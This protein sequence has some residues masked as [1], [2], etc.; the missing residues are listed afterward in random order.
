MGDGMARQARRTWATVAIGLGAAG[1][2]AFAACNGD[3]TPPAF[4]PEGGTS[5]VTTSDAS[6]DVASDAPDAA[7]ENA[8]VIT[9]HG[10]PDLP[11]FRVCFAIGT[12]GD[13][14]D[15][16]MAPLPPLPDR[17]SGSQPYPGIFPGTGGPM[18]DLLT[19]L[20]TK[21]IT[22]YLV[23]A[24]S[25]KTIE[26]VDGGTITGCDKLIGGDAGTLA[27]GTDYV[28]LGTI[29]PGTLA[30]NSTLVLVGTGCLPI[31]DDPSATSLRCGADYNG[32]T[33]NLAVKVFVLDRNVTDSAKVGVRVIHASQPL[34]G[35][36]NAG[37][38][39]GLVAS[40]TSVFDGGSGTATLVG[41]GEA[42][43]FGEQK[44]AKST[45]TTFPAAA[46]GT[47]TVAEA[48]ADGGTLVSAPFPLTTIHQLST[49]TTT[50]ADA[51]FANGQNVVF[52][53]VGDPSVALVTDAGINGYG[54][55]VLGFPTNPAVV[56]YP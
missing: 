52:V 12:K 3:D 54:L 1:L 48:L 32:G 23:F 30:K 19:D 47:L 56:P 34:D 39:V 50:G 17:R 35:V 40:L 15:A 41:P 5:D 10:S 29:P 42:L 55:H 37:G 14:S 26:R 24:S 51:Y 11:A 43:K 53:V 49:G 31:A 20:S 18:P 45:V 21:A 13:G 33:G 16:L 36:A 6:G 28:K 22:P 46:D 9:V 2:L 8:K 25:V 7:L 44:P 4:F 27:L 38:A